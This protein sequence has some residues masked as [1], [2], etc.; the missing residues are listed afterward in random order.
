MLR[1][2]SSEGARPYEEEEWAVRVVLRR[3]PAAAAH[4]ARSAAT[5]TASDAPPVRP[6][7]SGHDMHRRRE[8]GDS[9]ASGA[10]TPSEK[11]G[12]WVT[13]AAAEAPTIKEA[14]ARGSRKSEGPVVLAS[15]RASN[16][17]RSMGVHAAWASRRASNASQEERPTGSHESPGA[18]IVVVVVVV[19]REGPSSEEGPRREG[20]RP[21]V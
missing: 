11:R 7:H 12:A 8:R 20:G 9:A 13:A 10:D 21:N 1:P 17:S 14:L 4:R 5:V 2:T 15:R 16:A 6:R 3:R 19:V 18:R